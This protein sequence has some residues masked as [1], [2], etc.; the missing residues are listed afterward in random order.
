MVRQRFDEIVRD[1][2]NISNSLFK[3]YYKYPSPSIMHKVLNETRGIQRNEIQAELI[4]NGL[5]DIKKD[6]D[7]ENAPKKNVHKIEKK[8]KRILLKR[9]FTLMRMKIKIS[10]G[11]A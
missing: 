1:Q 6:I 3:K 4:K 5:D 2:N 10:K 9:I 11:K 7:I 8:K